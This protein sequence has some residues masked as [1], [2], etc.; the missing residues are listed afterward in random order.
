MGHRN[1][2]TLVCLVSISRRIMSIISVL[3]LYGLLLI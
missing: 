2:D 3:G 1:T